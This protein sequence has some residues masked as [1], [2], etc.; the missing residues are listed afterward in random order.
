MSPFP[1]AGYAELSQIY[2]DLEDFF[3]KQLGVDKAN[4]SMLIEEINKMAKKDSPNVDIIGKRLIDVGRLVLKSGFDLTL[5]KAIARLAEVKFLPKPAENGCKT[6]VGKSDD[7]CIDDHR[8][9]ATAFKHCGILL[10]FSAEEVHVLSTLFEHLGL[11]DKYLSRAVREE[12]AVGEEI[13]EHEASAKA[14]RSKAYALY[15]CDLLDLDEILSEQDITMV[16]WIQKPTY[17]VPDSSPSRPSNENAPSTSPGGHFEEAFERGA[18]TLSSSAPAFTPVYTVDLQDHHEG[19]PTRPNSS[20]APPPLYER[21]VEQ[22]V[23]NAFRAR[24]WDI[25]PSPNAVSLRDASNND[26]P[27]LDHDHEETFGSRKADERAHDSRIGASGEA[28]VFE[29]LRGLGLPGFTEEN[30]RSNMRRELL[31]HARYVNLGSWIGRET[32]DF[33]Y[34]D[35]DGSLTRYL[36]EN[37]FGR[38]PDITLFRDFAQQP[39]EYFLEVKSTTSSCNTRFYMSGSQYLR[40]Y[41][42]KLEYMKDCAVPTAG[43]PVNRVYV[44]LRVSDLGPNTDMKIFVDP[45]PRLGNDYIRFEAGTWHCTTQD[46]LHRDLPL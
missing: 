15:C 16:D 5:S 8:R 19:S 9:F 1:L 45:Y 29:I 44:I 14:F 22:V 43:P 33:V 26:V 4:P 40:V 34:T 11:S 7:F 24:E 28:Y 3:V 12:S 41:A 39:I 2:P 21:F 20:T 30:W 38:W 46:T 10:D 13:I 6:L 17:N 35:R 25:H 27:A 32:A 37:C 18:P 42:T 36:R 31:A 23:Q